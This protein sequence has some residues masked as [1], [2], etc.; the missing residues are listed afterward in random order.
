[1]SE[2]GFTGFTEFSGLKTC[3]SRYLIHF[4]SESG[5]TGFT[6]FSGLKT[7]L[8]RYLILVILKS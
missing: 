5:F 7:Y 6:E 3:L 2:S 1:L 4:L 8:S